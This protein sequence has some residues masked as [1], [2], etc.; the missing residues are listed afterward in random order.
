MSNT[1]LVTMRMFY[2]KN[3]TKNSCSYYAF[4]RK[5]KRL[6]EKLGEQS[7]IVKTSPTLSLIDINKSEMYLNLMNKSSDQ[8]K[9][10]IRKIQS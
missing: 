9:D 2:I 7:G 4:T 3:K 1:T 8:V 5:M 10:I 6:H